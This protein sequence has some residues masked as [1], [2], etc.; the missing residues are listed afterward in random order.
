MFRLWRRDWILSTMRTSRRVPAQGRR[1]ATL[2][3]L[4]RRLQVEPL[5]DRRLLASVT[6]SNLTDVVNGNVASI[7][8]LI[9]SH[10]GDGISLREAILAA[11]ADRAVDT[12]DFGSLSGTIQLTNVGH[13]GQIAIS[14]NVTINGPG[15]GVL[16]IRA[17]AGATSSGDGA[18]IFAVDDGSATTFANVSISGLTLTAGD[19][20]LSDGPDGGAIF[21]NENL[22]LTA[23]AISNNHVSGTGGRGGGV[24]SQLGSLTISAST[25]SGNTARHGGG[26]Y[27]ASPSTTIR[28]STISANSATVAV[29]NGGGIAVR[30]V[31]GDTTTIINS[32]VSGN[33]AARSGGGIFNDGAGSLIVSH[34]TITL[35]IAS[36][37]GSGSGIQSNYATTHLDHTIV[38]GN[39]LFGLPS[40]R[41][42]L[43]GSATSVRY[44]LIGDNTG[45][46]ITDN[47]GNQIGTGASPIEALLAPLAENAGPTLTHALLSGSPA[48]DA[49]DPAAAAGIGTVSSQDQ[50]GAVFVRVAD[51]DGTG[52]GR[53]DIGAYERQTLPGLD[54]VVDTLADE[55]NHDYSE[56]DRSLREAIDLANG[57]V[58][59]DTISFAAG[60]T[61]GGPTTILLSRGQLVIGESLAINGPGANVLTISAY[62]PTPTMKNGDGSRIFNLDDGNASNVSNVSISGLTLSGG[63]RDGNGGAIWSNEHLTL[64]DSVISGNA[65]A[66]F[67][68]QG[69]GG[70]YSGY[71]GDLTVIRSVIASNSSGLE[72]GGIRKRGRRLVIEDSRIEMNVA[73]WVGGGVS[74]ADGV[75][76]EISRTSITANVTQASSHRGGGGL[77]FY[78]A[79]VAIRDSLISGNS[80]LFIGGGIDSSFTDLSMIGSTVSGNTSASHGGGLHSGNGR[81]LEIALSTITANMAPAGFAGGVY[82]SGGNIGSRVFRSSI[83]AGNTNSDVESDVTVFQSAGY[84]LVG[85]GNGASLFNQ[86]GDQTGHTP[87]TLKLGPL[88]DNGGPTWTHALLAG[89]PAI[90]AG[91]PATM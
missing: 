3:S 14:N 61:G 8:A 66:G 91:D 65:S 32:T 82:A 54:L 68:T 27:T 57:S 56:G 9:G 58:G 60:L 71:G 78:N 46:T 10:G 47:G 74:A 41:G 67:T 39:L 80:S 13:V 49:G 89:S 29:A 1:S 26:I 59:A 63:D 76:V 18:R 28:N 7:E 55:I 2:F 77:F 73:F 21:N 35:N 75:T 5:E 31:A 30:T 48:I 22:T 33:R 16:T 45:A 36:V 34:C 86:P 72:G 24:F 83:I 62:D 4:H 70:I 81:T 23:C 64:V 12:I 44:S 53:I 40:A 15:A 52:A 51:G 84:N 38:A 6:V 17:F 19:P 50:R 90:D 79:T 42:D 87:E 43:A 11:N 69:G 85:T 25:I 88:A 37:I 20:A